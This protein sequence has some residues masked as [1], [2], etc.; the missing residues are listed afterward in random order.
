MELSIRQGAGRPII[1]TIPAYAPACPEVTNSSSIARNLRAEAGRQQLR[2]TSRQQALFDSW[3]GLVM[4]S[5]EAHYRHLE[6][7][8]VSTCKSQLGECVFWNA[9]TSSWSSE[10]CIAVNVTSISV[11]CA[12]DHLTDFASRFAALAEANEEV[13]ETGISIGIDDLQRSPAVVAQIAAIAVVVLVL[14]AYVTRLDQ[15]QRRLFELAVA[16]DE[17][18]RFVLEMDAIERRC[19]IGESPAR[20]L[21]SDT[22][23]PEK[24]HG[25]R[26]DSVTHRAMRS[27]S[28]AIQ[29]AYM[30]SSHDVDLE[31]LV[32]SRGA[33]TSVDSPS[34]QRATGATAAELMEGLTDTTL[35]LGQRCWRAAPLLWPMYCLRLQQQHICLQILERYDHAFDRRLRLALAVT[36][37]LTAM[38]AS[39]VFFAV[40]DESGAPALDA[41]ETIVFSMLSSIVQ[42]PVTVFVARMLGKAADSEF[43][44]R[45]FPLWR[46][47][48]LRTAAERILLV[49]LRNTP[50]SLLHRSDAL[51][52]LRSQLIHSPSVS[53][54]ADSHDDALALRHDASADDDGEQAA[55]A[56]VLSADEAA[57]NNVGAGERAAIQPEAPVDDDQSSAINSDYEADAAIADETAASTDA[58]AAEA[59]AAGGPRSRVAIRIGSI[60]GDS[61]TDSDSSIDS[62]RDR[63]LQQLEQ[64]ARGDLDEA[65]LGGEADELEQDISAAPAGCVRAAMPSRF[66][67][68]DGLA[69]RDSVIVSIGNTL[70]RGL[71]LEVEQDESRI[72]I[73]LWPCCGRCSADRDMVNQREDAIAA[74]RAPFGPDEHFTTDDEVRLGWFNAPPWCHR[75][76]SRLVAAIGRRSED[77]DQALRMARAVHGRPVGCCWI[78]Q[79]LRHDLVQA[80]GTPEETDRSDDAERT[81]RCSCSAPLVDITFRLTEPVL[82]PCLS[83]EDEHDKTKWAQKELLR[84][85]EELRD[86]AS[87]PDLDI[88]K[89]ATQ[90][91]RP[92]GT[93]RDHTTEAITWTAFA[94]IVAISLWY[95]LSFGLTVG[96]AAATNWT[97][98]FWTAEATTL[99]LVQPGTILALTLWE[100]I[101]APVLPQYVGWLPCCACVVRSQATMLIDEGQES[102]ASDAISGRISTIA[103][104]QAAGVA[105]GLD[106]DFALL[107]Y[108]VTGSLAV[109]VASRVARR[110]M[111]RA[112]ASRT[113]RTLRRLPTSSESMPEPDSG[114][115]HD[116]DG[117]QL[118]DFLIEQY[119]RMR[120]QGIRNRE[121]LPIELSQAARDRLTAMW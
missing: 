105:S 88:V 31:S 100:L 30:G 17:E 24:S 104:A 73:A 70:T 62:E 76:C 10:G 16:Q 41:V 86:A 3:Y 87:K 113:T 85:L 67:G 55:D 47:L 120:Y 95:L 26:S 28:R 102:I 9:T 44:R 108:G 42:L 80:L 118:R 50:R 46:E 101:I 61:F 94:A 32:S 59:E 117:L 121:D 40:G 99:V 38:V 74:T 84:A 15:K 18:V 34:K 64:D 49:A 25:K 115:E 23:S 4:H 29:R 66:E 54:D 97:V 63:E 36:A 60:D 45:Y 7:A 107:A 5:E 90:D 20:W 22:T 75:H 112:I 8:S 65:S 39:A 21:P 114:T 92:K 69:L 77:R 82:E 1:V 81:S 11:T 119:L 52:W 78:G 37:M 2:L 71:R 58:V 68:V 106:R 43:R 83:P 116:E 13:L 98:S 57:S 110:S 12:C 103:L 53:M 79:A 19:D 48:R 93:C 35:G 14:F 91:A 111:T 96:Q 89:R 51:Q 27:F 72:S 109:M 33:A 56:E 6:A